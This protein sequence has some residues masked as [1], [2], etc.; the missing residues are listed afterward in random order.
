MFIHT[1]T[2]LPTEEPK[3]VAYFQ[4]QEETR[5]AAGLGSIELAVPDKGMKKPP[6]KS[7][8]ASVKASG[9]G[10]LTVQENPESLRNRPSESDLQPSPKRTERKRNR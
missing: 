3:S 2:R 5:T 6:K 4:I 8:K 9:S 7:K 1:S 10:S